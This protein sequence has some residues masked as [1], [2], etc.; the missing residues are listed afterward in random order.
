[1][2]NKRNSRWNQRLREIF[3][4]W[5]TN[6]SGSI[7]V[8]QM[9]EIYRIYK[10]ELDLEELQPRVGLGGQVKKNDFVEF[11]LEN[12]LLDITGVD[13]GKA[14]KTAGSVKLKEEEGK[15]PSNKTKKSREGGLLCCG[16][17]TGGSPERPVNMD[18][19]EAAFRK[20]DTD[21]DGFIDW[22]EFKQVSKNIDS[23]QARR[24]FETCDQ[25]GDA[26]ISLEEFR[27]MANMKTS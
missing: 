22:E 27:K 12:K 26:K 16:K 15:R 4:E 17:G 24:I 11:S 10:V 8:D 13:H 5:D 19:V 21:G 1:M 9:S 23:E 7:S 6:Q 25:S 14:R 2:R 18:R 3:E 20:F